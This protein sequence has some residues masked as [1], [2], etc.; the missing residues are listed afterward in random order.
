MH[1][2]AVF[3]GFLG[4]G[5]TTAMMAVTKYWTGHVGKAALIS[6]DRGHGGTL[7]DHRLASLSGCAASEITG[8]CICFVRDQLSALL[9]DYY[10]RGYDLVLSDI[11]GFGVGAL[12]HVYH[13]MA[14]EHPDQCVLAPFTVF[15]EPRS[16][17]VLRGQLGDDMAP[18]LHAQ[19]MEADLIVLNKCDL[20]DR[21]TEAEQTAWLRE[22]FPEAKVLSV[23]AVTGDGI[24]ELCL[25]LKEGKASLHRPDIDYE[26]AD[27]LRAMDSLAEYY[28]QYHAVV[29]CEDF[30][31]T[32][33]LRE[34]AEAIRRGIGAASGAAPHF[35]LLAWGPEGDYGKV[36]LLG[37]G[38]PLEVP[39][40][41][42]RPCTE[43]A[44]LLNTSARCPA[45]KLTDL[46]MDA[47]RTVSDKFRLELM[48][49][50]EECFDLGE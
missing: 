46:V 14:A 23:S 10:E 38:R 25:A 40:A 39:H 49:F 15:I 5:K 30:D 28:L 22:H 17:R 8:E 47:V 34:L 48:I 9:N 26:D 3:S 11:P 36:D 32:A 43:I 13:G 33:Y 2:F 4:A 27:L 35:K 24:P 37:V 31:G 6:N 44:V 42:A 18:I 50:K 45:Q 16:V 20:L 1:R 12:E 29:C 19:L 41:F 7:A 21:E